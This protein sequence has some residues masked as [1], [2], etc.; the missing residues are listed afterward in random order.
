MENRSRQY[1]I[2]VGGWEHEVLNACFYPRPTAGSTEKLAYYARFFDA[3]EV[4]PTFWDDALSADDARQWLEAV[5]ESRTFLFSVK[6]HSSFTH[7]KGIRPQTTRNI[8]AILQELARPNRLGALLMQFPYAFTNTSSNRFY[9][10]RLAE[11]FA[12]FPLHVEFRNDSWNQPSLTGFLE[13]NNLQL[14]SADLPRIRQFMPFTTGGTPGD[15]YVRLH[16]RNEKGWLLNGMDTRYD[17]LYNGRE[18]HEIRRRIEA[19]GRNC[20]RTIIVCNNTTGGKAVA[21][22]LQLRSALRE[23][24]PVHVPRAS[25]RAF[26]FLQNIAQPD[27]AETSLFS[28]EPY[29]EAM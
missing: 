25:L 21:N 2:G 10:V 20:S 29:R 19:T 15:L 8:R 23:G 24:K 27:E 6:L 4:R 28:G 9:L 11:L 18:I 5:G 17:Y 26:P 12:G 1:L 16:G 22:A 13:E 7:K 14:V 3:V